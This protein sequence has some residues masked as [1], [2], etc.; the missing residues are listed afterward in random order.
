[1]RSWSC[2]CARRLWRALDLGTPGVRGGRRPEGDLPHAR[3]DGRVRAEGPPR[4]GPYAC[5]RRLNC[6]SDLGRWALLKW[7]F[8]LKRGPWPLAVHAALRVALWS[9]MRR[10]QFAWL[11]KPQATRLICLMTRLWPSV[12]AFVTPS[13][14]NPSISG[15]QRSIVVARRG[16]RHG[17]AGHAG[18]GGRGGHAG[19]AGGRQ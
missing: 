4:R 19:R 18:R 13:S 3:G 10:S 1:M 14:R 2:T 11:R 5:V 6:C 16:R 17:R 15:H 9:I 12:R 7:L 8:A